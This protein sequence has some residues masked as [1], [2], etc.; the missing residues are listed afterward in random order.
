R[1][2]TVTINAFYNATTLSTTLDVSAWPA[3]S[4]VLDGDALANGGTMGGTVTL[5][6]KAPAGGTTVALASSE[7]L[8]E[9]PTSVLVPA[10]EYSARFEVES[11][12][13]SSIRE[14]VSIVA[15]TSGA[16]ASTDLVLG[17]LARPPSCRGR[18]CE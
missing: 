9:L 3:L 14:S 6:A 15:S 7:P 12:R 1:S 17:N 18:Q 13:K 8:L 11:N 10:G 16:N 4:I 5:N 2:E